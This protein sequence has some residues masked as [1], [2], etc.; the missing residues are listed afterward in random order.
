M[1][2]SKV[3]TVLI[4][5]SFLTHSPQACKQEFM[6]SLKANLDPI[7]IGAHFML[8]VVLVTILMNEY[9]SFHLILSV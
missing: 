3:L 8:L 1:W 4:L 6:A 7:V 2:P 9:A 5:R